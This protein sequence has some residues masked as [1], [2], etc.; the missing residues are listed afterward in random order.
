MLYDRIKLLQGADV[1]NLV[2][3]SGT[4]FPAS[5][6]LGE[7]FFRTD[8]DKL[9]VYKSS[10]WSEA[11]S[12]SF[13]TSANRN[14]TGVWTFTQPVVGVT[15]T[16]SNQYTTKS[17]VDT[18]IAGVGSGSGSVTSVSVSGG[19]TGL[20]TTGGPI[21]STGTITLGGTL[22]I[23][24]GGTGATTAAGALNAL[25]PSQSSQSG[26]YL[27]TD[28]FNASWGSISTS[29]LTG[30]ALPASVTTSSL[31]SVGNI[32]SGTWSG[33]F[34]D[35][36]GAN[37]T[38]LN[39]SNISSGTVAP[40]R[41]GSGTASSSSFL[42]GDGTWA[43][44][45]LSRGPDGA[46]QVKGGA[47]GFYNVEGYTIVNNVLSLGAFGLGASY[48]S[49]TN[50]VDIVVNAGNGGDVKLQTTGLGEVRLTS[51]SNIGFNNT[52][53][54]ILFFNANRAWAVNA[55]YGTSGQVLTSQGNGA[56]P[57]WANPSV[58]APANTLTGSTL[59]ANVTSSSLTSVGTITS[60]TWSGSFGAVSGANLT[61]L[62]A[63]NISSG[64]VAATR[65]GSGVPSAANFLRGDGS[66][67]PVVASELAATSTISTDV[68]LSGIYG[69]TLSGNSMF[70]FV[71]TAAPVGKRVWD[72]RVDS[73]GAFG[74]GTQ[75]DDA[76]SLVYAIKVDRVGNAASN[77]TL[78]STALTFNGPIT[79]NST[80]NAGAITATSFTGSGSGLS[81]LNA[82]ALTSGTVATARL[83]TGTADSTTYLRGDGTWATVSG[84]GGG[85]YTAGTG[86]SLSGNQFSLSTPVAVGNLGTGTPSASTF[87][88]GDGTWATPTASA[89]SLSATSTVNM[90]SSTTGAFAAVSGNAYYGLVTSTGSTDSKVSFIEQT[91]AG[92]NWRLSND[93]VNS[94]STFFSVTR[95]GINP[96]VLTLRANGLTFTGVRSDNTSNA[97]NISIITTAGGSTSGQSGA[98]A[99]GTG[100]APASVT[101]HVTISTGNAG[102]GASGNISGTTGT[103]S[104]FNTGAITWDTGNVSGTFTSGEVR[105]RTGTCTT[106]ATG[107]ATISTGAITSATS[108]FTTGGVTISTGNNAST[109]GQSG[110]ISLTTGNQ[111]TGGNSGNISVTTGTAAGAYSSGN[112]SVTTGAAT[113][114]ASGNFTVTLGA[115]AGAFLAGSA[116]ITA[117]NVTGGGA[118]AGGVTLTG[119]NVSAAGTGAA[120]NVTLTAGNHA[121]GTGTGGNININA[122]NGTGASAVGGNVTIKAG[123][124]V[125]AGGDI[126]FQT[127]TTTS[128]TTRV[129]IQNTGA[130]ETAVGTSL[131]MYSRSTQMNTSLS[132]TA[133]TTLN[134]ALGDVFNVSLVGNTTIAFSNVPASGRAYIMTLI[135]RQDATGNR[136]VTWP[137]SIKFDFG[138]PPTPDTNSNKIAVYR[139]MT[140]DGGT[141]WFGSMFG[142]SF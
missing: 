117:G 91:T 138:Q 12:A 115:T 6:D 110:A 139:L 27:T 136:I 119:G 1:E 36:S 38:S 49:T 42:R 73:N 140:I 20:T 52:A 86:L 69:G 63:S 109:G 74:I 56:P 2:V 45:A 51:S 16:A 21:T 43:I 116:S 98:L 87:L 62:N 65:L 77:I 25:L 64:T 48:I 54:S 106:G 80:L 124:G 141:T 39:A 132:S 123:T 22:N 60:G 13:D 135:M 121:N 122:G 40:A 37:L 71:N 32:T 14:I 8:Q 113:N 61:N 78:T 102:N 111:T 3:D 134:C 31:T 137:S 30:T 66:W 89:T 90:S 76:S 108:T 24:N 112:F 46:I 58:T 67:Q 59:A 33:S 26:K 96:T 107:N 55:S 92:I 4:T 128:S 84:G 7:L 130:I 75:P 125:S 47:N 50:G 5:P 114:G 81:A 44:P 103:S 126:L 133:T 104:T 127:S 82:S 129:T 95:T 88:R 101:N 34:G 120:G 19:S 28:G 105:M 23:A 100:H 118:A 93:A 11:G 72:M 18:A 41:L 10:G 94:H 15:P 85:T 57:T 17:Y 9:F 68:G 35:V 99:L 83:G 97:E 79:A 29:S 142:G 70:Q 131:D 53:G